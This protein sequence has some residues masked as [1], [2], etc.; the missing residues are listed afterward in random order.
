MRQDAAV[1]KVGKQPGHL[2]GNGHVLLAEGRFHASSG[3][4]LFGKG[5]PCLA[6]SVLDGLDRDRLAAG[7]LFD[8]TL[9]SRV[10]GPNHPAIS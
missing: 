2:A 8:G 9:E 1:G 4:F 3:P 6:Q 5:L 10:K 7:L